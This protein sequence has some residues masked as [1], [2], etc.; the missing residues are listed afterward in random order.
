MGWLVKSDARIDENRR[1][2]V[3]PNISLNGVV[4]PEF[5]TAVEQ[6]FNDHFVFRPQLVKTKSWVDYYMFK[7]AVTP[8]VYIGTN[9]WLYYR[10][11]LSDYLKN[12]CNDQ[13]G[14]RHLAKQLH[15]LENVIESSGRK[16]LFI[17][18]PNKST[19]YPEYVG[20]AR[21]PSRCNKSRYDL[22]LESFQEYPVSNFVRLDLLLLNAKDEHQVYFNDDTHWSIYAATIV[23]KAILNHLAP[24]LWTEYFPEIEL[25]LREKTGDLYIMLALGITEKRE[26]F[27]T[28]TYRS[29]VEIENRKP[30]ENGLPRYRI[31]AKSSYAEPLLPRMIIYRD[32]FMNT[33]L[34]ILKGC[35]RQ[36]DVYW[37]HDLPHPEAVEDLQASEIVLLEIV[38]RD[39][40]FLKIDPAAVEAVLTHGFKRKPSS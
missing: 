30:L 23:S 9:G 1:A 18:A 36:L 20:L 17:V 6:Y 27:K 26:S 39:L 11:E 12:S 4:S 7:T 32:S 15:E 24:D 5:Y 25:D 8:E 16:F 14:M 37:T 28:I 10:G 40:K 21:S 29:K 13:D 34:T 19:I 38:E 33:P 31:T 3:M 2:I 35:C 22:L